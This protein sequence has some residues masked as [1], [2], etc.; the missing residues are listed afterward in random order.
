MKNS[1]YIV[2]IG[3]G[4]L[5]LQLTNQ[6]IHIGHSVVVIVSLIKLGKDSRLMMKRSP[7]RN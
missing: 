1:L 7:K 5:G 2:T 6:L 4:R 3:C